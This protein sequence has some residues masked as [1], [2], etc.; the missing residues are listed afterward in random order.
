M[1]GTME[2]GEGLL[3]S[4]SLSSRRAPPHTAF[5]YVSQRRSKEHEIQSA[6]RPER[7]WDWS[8][9]CGEKGFS[10][11]HRD[12]WADVIIKA[13]EQTEIDHRGS[14]QPRTPERLRAL[15]EVIFY[16]VDEEI[17]RGKQ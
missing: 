14:V 17:K 8:C 7:G 16:A 12:H 5:Q 11:D 13:I 15:R 6:P 1:A 4:Q 2:L 3:E 10:G 9:T